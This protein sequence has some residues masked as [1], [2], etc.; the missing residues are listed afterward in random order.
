MSGVSGLSMQSPG[1]ERGICQLGAQDNSRRNV[2]HIARARGLPARS[3]RL[4]IPLIARQ[5]NCMEMSCLRVAAFA[6]GITLK[7]RKS[8]LPSSRAVFDSAARA[9]VNSCQMRALSAIALLLGVLHFH[10]AQA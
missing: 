2:K 10:A 3:S 9:N 6:Q 5:V 8:L 7:S 1:T 4:S